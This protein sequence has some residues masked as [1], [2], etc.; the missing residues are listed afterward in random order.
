MHVLLKCQL[1]ESLRK[2]LT[3]EIRNLSIALE[4]LCDTDKLSF[5]LSNHLI[6]KASAK[7]CHLILVR[8]R[9]ILY[10]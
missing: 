7:T 9:T 2:Q 1:Y 6:A 4:E 5:I 3:D 10:S 8:R